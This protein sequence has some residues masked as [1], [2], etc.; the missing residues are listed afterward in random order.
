MARY[1]TGFPQ[2]G[3]KLVRQGNGELRPRAENE[4]GCERRL[5]AGRETCFTQAEQRSAAHLGAGEREAARFYRSRRECGGRMAAADARAA[6]RADATHRRT[7]DPSR[8]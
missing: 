6:A 1:L 8:G 2:P 5:G 7:H 4:A 3:A